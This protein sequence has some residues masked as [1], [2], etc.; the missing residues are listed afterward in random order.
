MNPSLFGFHSNSVF[1]TIGVVAGVLATFGSA[2]RAGVSPRRMVA[3]QLLL[4]L[5]AFAGARVFLLWQIGSLRTP[6]AIP[7]QLGANRYPGGVLGVLLALPLIAR[8]FRL[9]VTELG[10]IVALPI[11]LAMAFIRVGCFLG[12]CCFGTVSNLPW[13][14]TFPK[15][16]IPWLEHVSKNYILT[17]AASSLPVH[18]LQLYFGLWSLAVALLL[19]YLQPRRRHP[20]QLLLVF[21]FVHEGGKAI[22]ESLRECPHPELQLASF[23]VAGVAGTLLIVGAIRSRTTPPAGTAG[24][25]LPGWLAART[26]S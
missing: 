16:S 4:L 15:E 23:L 25:R 12:G 21:L 3:I 22:L 2:W 20:G 17:T 26:S 13:A 1:I 24:P 14:V 19:F 5:A 10:D 8:F 9:S 6:W 18:P 7:I 11:A